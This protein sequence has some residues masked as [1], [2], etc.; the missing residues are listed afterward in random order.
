AFHIVAHHIS[1]SYLDPLQMYVGG[2]GGT[3]KS[4]FINVLLH[5]FV[6]QNCHFVIVVSAP[7]RNA[8]AL[9]RGSTYHFLLG[10]NGQVKYTGKKTLAEVCSRLNGVE[11]M[12]LDE[13]SMLSC[14]DMYKISE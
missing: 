7:T 10:L 1:V 14:I 6:A 13:V 2:M 4:Q 12:V 9:L 5:F 8:A 11:Y 3:G